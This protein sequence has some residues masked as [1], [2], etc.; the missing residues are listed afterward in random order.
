[1]IEPGKPDQNPYLDPFN[2]RFRDECLNERWFMS[3]ALARAEI[4]A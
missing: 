1:L 2:G 3:L 4:E